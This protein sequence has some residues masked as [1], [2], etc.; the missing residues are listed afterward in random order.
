MLPAKQSFRQIKERNGQFTLS[1][2]VV[3]GL[4]TGNPLVQKPLFQLGSSHTGVDGLAV[5]LEFLK[6]LGKIWNS[7]YS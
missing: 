3:D 6:L 4:G 7:V 1:N 2:H 5:I